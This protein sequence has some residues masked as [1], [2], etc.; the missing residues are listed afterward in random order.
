VT[1]LAAMLVVP[2]AMRWFS[3]RKSTANGPPTE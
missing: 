1:A 2:L 3:S